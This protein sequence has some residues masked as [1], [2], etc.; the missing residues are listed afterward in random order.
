MSVR[1]RLCER[2]RVEDSQIVLMHT[3]C[4][5]LFVYACTFHSLGISDMPAGSSASCLPTTHPSIAPRGTREKNPA[6]I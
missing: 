2:R 5:P 6:G 1:V 3:L 4:M